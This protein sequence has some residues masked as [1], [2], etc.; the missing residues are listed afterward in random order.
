MIGGMAYGE[1]VDTTRDVIYPAVEDGISYW[2]YR[3][4]TSSSSGNLHGITLHK[5]HLMR[6]AAQ[7][8]SH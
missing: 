3:V 2:T 8:E 5:P 1:D 6:L 4:T 7:S